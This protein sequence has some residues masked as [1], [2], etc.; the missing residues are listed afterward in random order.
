MPAEAWQADSVA[1]IVPRRAIRANSLACLVMGVEPPSPAMRPRAD[2]LRLRRLPH[3]PRTPV[4]AGVAAGL[5]DAALASLAVGLHAVGA[6]A[7]PREREARLGDGGRMS[8][9]TRHV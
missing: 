1:A 2:G 3:G 9:A 8:A 6:V 5:R 7:R 4:R